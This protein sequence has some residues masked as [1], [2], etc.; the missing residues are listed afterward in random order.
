MTGNNS[1]D[2]VTRVCTDKHFQAPGVIFEHIIGAPPYKE[3]RF[4]TG[5]LAYDITLNLKQRLVAQIIIGVGIIRQKP[6]EI[7]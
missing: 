4:L 7:K 2:A 1:S 3:A 5:K 6:T